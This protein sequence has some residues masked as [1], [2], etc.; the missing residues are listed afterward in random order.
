LRDLS[1]ASIQV[2]ILLWEGGAFRSLRKTGSWAI[3]PR[4]RSDICGVMASIPSL[5][6]WVTI[7]AG[8]PVDAAATADPLAPELP[9]D[10]QTG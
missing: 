2:A 10:H 1:D 4:R 3:F 6:H 8:K 5:I 7:A 9:G